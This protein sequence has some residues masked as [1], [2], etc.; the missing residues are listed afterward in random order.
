MRTLILSTIMSA[1]ALVLLSACG[2]TQPSRFYVLN[3]LPAPEEGGTVTP[4]PDLTLG[5]GPVNLPKMLDRPQIVT[6]SGANQ[7]DLSE[8]NRWAE[9]LDYNFTRMLGENLSRLLG[10]DRIIYFPWNIST[11]IDYQ[12][13]VEVIKFE[14]LENGNARL[15]ARWT[16]NRDRSPL[17]M[18]TSD[19]TRSV[20]GSGYAPIVAA[21]SRTLDDLSQEI[22]AAIRSFAHGSHPG[23]R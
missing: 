14:T 4:A 13:S 16:I 18:R 10:T 5:I 8:P 1:I 23:A 7:I 19:I 15:R 6:R 11:R 3:S 9:P 20:T 12:V 22:A 21:Q 2:S 17:A